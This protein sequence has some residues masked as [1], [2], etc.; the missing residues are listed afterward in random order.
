MEFLAKDLLEVECQKN[1]SFHEHLVP[2]N[3]FMTK[4][5][6]MQLLAMAGVVLGCVL[7]VFVYIAFNSWRTKVRRSQTEKLKKMKSLNRTEDTK[8]NIEEDLPPKYNS[9]DEPP[10]YESCPNFAD[11]CIV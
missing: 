2:S 4:T 9:L 10:S 11:E 1:L 7:I 3:S 5:D 6:K 8:V